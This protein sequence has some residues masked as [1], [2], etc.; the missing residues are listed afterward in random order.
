MDIK[1]LGERVLIELL[2]ANEEVSG[3]IIPEAF[4]ESS[5]K[6]K[7][8]AV[9]SDVKDVEVGDTVLLNGGGM[10]I[11]Y[12]DNPYKLVLLNNILAVV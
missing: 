3:I 7:V 9:G 1:L 5:N 2:P 12:Q 10:D 4:R 6:G 8:M 11:T